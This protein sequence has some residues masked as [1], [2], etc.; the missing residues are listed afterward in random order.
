[1]VERADDSPECS[2][3]FWCRPS[4]VDS[5]TSSLTSPYTTNTVAEAEELSYF[6]QHSFSS[7]QQ[8][9]QSPT[10]EPPFWDPV[11]HQQFNHTETTSSSR[12]KSTTTT[13]TTTCVNTWDEPST[14][15]SPTSA[16]SSGRTIPTRRN[17]TNNDSDNS[18][19]YKRRQTKML[20][21]SLIESF[22]RLYGDSPDANRKVFFLI[23]Q[24]LKSLGIVDAEFVDEMVSVRTTFQHTFHKLFYAALHTVQSDPSLLAQQQQQQKRLLL[25]T[26]S[27]L[28]MVSPPAWPEPTRTSS[29]PNSNKAL[30]DL[31][32]HPSRYHNDFVELG[33]LG[34]GGFAHA[35]KVKN[36]LD[37]IDYAVKKVSLGRDLKRGKTPYGKIFREIKH[38]AR[39]EHPNVIRYYASWLEYDAGQIQQD[40]EDEEDEEDEF[41]NMD[42]DDNDDD[43]DVYTSDYLTGRA[44]LRQQQRQKRPPLHR[45][46]T[47]ELLYQQGSISQPDSPIYS[48]PRDFTVHGGWTLFIQMQLCQTTLYD[49]IEIRNRDYGVVDP[50][51]NLALFSRILQG[52]AYIHDQGLIHRDLKPSNIFLTLPCPLSEMTDDGRRASWQILWDECIPKIG[53][54]GLAAALV[55]EQDDVV[56]PGAKC[57]PPPLRRTH[58]IGI[59]TRTY[60]SPEQLN[61]SGRP[62]DEKV[63]IYSLGLI[64]FELYQPFTTWME[65]ADAIS[66]LKNAMLPDGFV[67]KYPKESALILWMMDQNPERRPSVTQLLNYEIFSSQ[68][69]ADMLAT[70]TAKLQAKSEALDTQSKQMELMKMEMKRME[71]ERQKE[72]DDLQ[73]KLDELQDKL[74]SM[75]K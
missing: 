74:D 28:A 66:N 48:P 71:L 62:Y 58:T 19:R 35:Y 17:S 54:F 11:C 20:L 30:F 53:D 56:S 40:E 26:R 36:K 13:T 55:D 3:Y 32:I 37:G 38:L 18:D 33:L 22:C 49:Y 10:S 34:R 2:S 41:I 47:R 5:D 43:D 44:P 6:I 7:T 39:L 46:K 4:E 73:R 61:Y 21:V 51:K 68:P 9:C 67:E 45:R 50:E 60:A 14:T 72:R 70:L 15:E 23:C 57:I 42:D 65:R 63:D 59:G 75:C 69:P 31:S 29:P 25:P 27:S 8:Q 16:N 24:T 12:A 1:M 64:F 52:T